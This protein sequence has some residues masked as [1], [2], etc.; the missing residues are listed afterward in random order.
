MGPL[1]L[2][3]IKQNIYGNSLP[4]ATHAVDVEFLRNS[5]AEVTGTLVYAFERLIDTQYLP[6][7]ARPV[8]SV[9]Y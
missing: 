9:F 1:I 6:Q 7:S 5:E 8:L 2:A 3:S 4:L